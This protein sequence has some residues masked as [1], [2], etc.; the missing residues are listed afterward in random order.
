MK[1]KTKRI[2]INLLTVIFVLILVGVLLA[3]R[4][5]PHPDTTEEIA[6]CIGKNAILYTQLGCHACETQE[7]MFGENYQH[8][9]V[10][11][12]FYDRETCTEKQIEY[13]PTW[14]INNEKIIGVQSI[15]KLQELTGC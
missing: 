12:C 14:I 2:V 15:E 10:V 8:L 5:S 9:N 3:V 4:K 13:T 6:K 7:Q 11:D 1:N